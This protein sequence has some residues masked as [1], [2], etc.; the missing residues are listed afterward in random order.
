[1]HTYVAGLLNVEEKKENLSG[2]VFKSELDLFL[3]DSIAI[4]MK[5][6]VK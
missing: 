1:M 5:K 3:K 6:Y 2:Q 4:K